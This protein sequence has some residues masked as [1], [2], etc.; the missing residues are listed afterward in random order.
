MNSINY[1]HYWRQSEIDE[2]SI[3]WFHQFQIIKFHE[4]YC[5]FSCSEISL[6]CNRKNQLTN[7]KIFLSSYV[8]VKKFMKNRNWWL[9]LIKPS[10]RGNWSTMTVRF[11]TVFT[12]G[13]AMSWTD[14]KLFN[15]NESLNWY[16]LGNSFS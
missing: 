12:F 16:V 1:F 9:S 2:L 11:C 13:Q 10:A 7:S 14:Q 5:L 4:C 3:A 6:L 8:L 15:T